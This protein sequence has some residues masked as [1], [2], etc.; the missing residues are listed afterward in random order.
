MNVTEPLPI[1]RSAP[2]GARQT[3][4]GALEAG[5]VEPGDVRAVT[6]REVSPEQIQLDQGPLVEE[7]H[8]DLVGEDSP[9]EGKEVEFGE[10]DG[11]EF[12]LRALQESAMGAPSA[13][14]G[15]TNEAGIAGGRAET[16]EQRAE[17][18]LQELMARPMPDTC[19]GET[20]A[21]PRPRRRC[22]R[23]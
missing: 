12:G 20:K 16:Q 23:R 14:F 2:P 8:P 17:R 7:L 19:G 22:R 10:R 3:A 18:E 1:E 6:Q 21:K 5:E 11:P 13:A 15:P 9:H 4:K